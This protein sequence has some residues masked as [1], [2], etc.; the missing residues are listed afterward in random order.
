[1]GQAVRNKSIIYAL[2]LAFGLS[3]LFPEVAFSAS[4]SFRKSGKFRSSA[5]H[6][7]HRF[8]GRFGSGFA[9]G[10]GP[11]QGLHRFDDRFDRSGFHS[12]F[13]SELGFVGGSV[14]DV[15]EV[16]IIQVPSSAAAPSREPARIGTYMDPQWVDGGHGVEVLRPGRWG[17]EKQRVE[18]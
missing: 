9:I 11:V 6:N 4:R 14:V 1:M 8:T 12:R 18:R 15:G 5:V 10:F 17:D 13:G 3:M 2:V 16:V 7:Q